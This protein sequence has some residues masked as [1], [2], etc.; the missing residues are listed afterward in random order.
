MWQQMLTTAVLVA[1]LRALQPCIQVGVQPPFVDQSASDA[2]ATDCWWAGAPLL[3]HDAAH[4][5][6]T[7]LDGVG[8]HRVAE[9]L[10]HNH[11]ELGN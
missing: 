7:S 4:N 10:G 2:L 1:Q 8:S 9:L 5:C 11:H 3:L 6:Q